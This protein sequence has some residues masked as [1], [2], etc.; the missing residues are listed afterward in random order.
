MRM[1]WRVLAGGAALLGAFAILGPLQHL[2]IVPETA[3]G[4]ASK[5]MAKAA[6][7]AIPVHGT[8]TYTRPA[9]DGADEVVWRFGR[10]PDIEARA[11]IRA[12]V[13]TA[14]YSQRRLLD[15]AFASLRRGEPGRIDL[16]LL[17]VAGDGSQE[18]FRREVDYVGRQF[19]ELFGAAGRT[20]A[21]VNSRSTAATAPKATVTSIREA[22]IAIAARMQ[23]EEDILFLFLT[24]HG[25]KDHELKLHESGMELPGVR[26]PTLA[27]LLEESGIRWKVV[28]VSACYGGGFIE[29]LQ[30]GRSL[31]IAAARKDRRSFGCRDDNDF[32]YFGRAYFKESLPMAAS[33]E[34]AFRNAEILVREWELDPVKNVARSGI[35]VRART[36]ENR[37]YP[38]ISISPA[39]QQHL[40]RWIA[41]SR[42]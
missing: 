28:V 39:M 33:F 22:L 16:Y 25:S 18:V 6:L 20:V 17:A 1:K 10:P 19:A 7:H 23:V 8:L 14:L 9:P 5:A 21:L 27:R 11:R 29:P 35:N 31:I 36:E 34:D 3:I 30:D 41:G 24:S 38:Q 32:T 13:E 15:Q 2:G 4:A 42:P 40:G 26:A 37:S 12:N